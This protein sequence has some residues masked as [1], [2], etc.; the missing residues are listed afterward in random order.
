[1]VLLISFCILAYGNFKVHD[2][3]FKGTH[4]EAFINYLISYATTYGLLFLFAHGLYSLKEIYTKQRALEEANQERKMAELHGLKAQMNP[5]FLFNTLN[6]IYA[7]AL[8]KDER[9]ADLIMKLSDNFRYMLHAGQLDYVPIKSEIDHMKDYVSLQSARLADKLEADLTFDIE[10]N[11]KHIAPLLM[12]PF[13]ENAFKYSSA[14]R[15]K[16]HRIAVSVSLRRGKFHF[17]CS[18]AFGELN[19]ENMD[20]QWQK[21][22]IGISNTRKRLEAV[23]PNQYNLSIQKESNTF[24]VDLT[25]LL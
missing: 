1:M 16:G 9:S 25:I 15:G 4:D 2:W 12:M 14:L 10:D 23:Y 5:H 3:L 18:N 22:G 17:H 19:A 8:K 21:S 11:D 20:S 7:S 24:V 6:T 13:V